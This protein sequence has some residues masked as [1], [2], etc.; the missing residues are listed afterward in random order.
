MGDGGGKDTKLG[1]R[2]RRP[3]GTPQCLHLDLSLRV[4]PPLHPTRGHVPL[5]TAPPLTCGCA[6][7]LLP[8]SLLPAG[9]ET[10]PGLE[11]RQGSA[12]TQQSK[13][14]RSGLKSF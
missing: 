9:A 5:P 12:D 13:C 4:A 3:A 6:E 11:G 7:Q 14:T 1:T 10:T 8:S 2:C